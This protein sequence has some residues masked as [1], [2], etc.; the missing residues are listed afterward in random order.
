M[1]ANNLVS[2]EFQILNS[3]TGIHYVNEVESRLKFRPFRNRTNPNSIATGLAEN[4]ADAPVL[5]FSDEIQ[6]Y[7]TGVL[8][9]LLDRLNLMLCRGQLQTSVRNI[10]KNRLSE[11]IQNENNYDETDIVHDAIY[12]IMISPNYTILK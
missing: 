3:T 7:Q 4:A 9:A 2:P 12:F 8:D 5:D 10:I 6:A 11:N 1:E